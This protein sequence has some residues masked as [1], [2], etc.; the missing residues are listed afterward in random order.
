MTTLLNDLR[1]AWRQL[2]KAPGFTVTA[3]LTLALGIGISAAMFTVVD[4]VLLQPLPVPHSSQIVVLGETNNAGNLSPSSLP[5]L[6][7]W[8]AQSKSFQDI[9]WYTQKFF[10]M[11][12]ADGTTQFSI[13][14][15]TSPNFFS[16]LR[17]QPL[18]GRTFL[19]QAGT[20]GNQGTV[21]LSDFVWQNN[22]HS[23]KNIVGKQIQLGAD[24]YTVVGVLPQQFYIPS[25]D[26][27][28]F[29]WTVLPHI[30]DME[31]RG[32]GFLSGIGR[33]HPGVSVASAQAELS[34]IQG[35]LARQFPDL[36]MTK[37]VKV[38]DY[39]DSL[40]ASARPALL[41]LQAAVLLVWLIACANIAGLMLTRMAARRKEIAVRA[42]LGAAR[43]RIVRQFL[44]ESLVIGV[45]GGACG[46]GIAYA[47]L[48]VLRHSIDAS[49]NRSHEIALNWHVILLLITLSVVSAVIFGT[50]PAFQ[51]SSAD[52]QEA[53]HETS[54]GA[55]A[56]VKQVRLRNA[57]IVGELALSLV[58]LVSAGLMLRTLYALR[59]VPVGFNP[60]HL[61]VAQFFSK[62]GFTP[63]AA[64]PNSADIR[65]A[66]YNPLLQRVRTVPGV[67]SAALVTATPLTNNVHMNASF[68]VIGN[69]AANAAGRSV[70]LHAVTPGAYRTL[71]IR[72]L[73]GRVFDDG[74]RIGTLPV[75][76]VNQS[77]A[78]Q[79]LGSEP[80]QQRL[81]L[82]A[83]SGAKSILQNISVIGVVEDTP[84]VLGQPAVPQVDI[85]LN[86]LPIN[87][88]FYPIVSMA[89][90]LAVRTTQP[91]EVIVP[92]ISRIFSNQNADI[93][94]NS[95]QTMP[96]H[97][98][99]Q[100][101]SQTLAARL[102]WIFAIAAVLIAAAGLYGLL[103]Y[104]VGQRTREIGVRLALGAQRGDVLRMILRQ[105]AR[106]L[107]FGLVIG[108]FAAFFTTRLVRSFLYGVDQHDL[109]TIVAVSILLLAVGLVASYLPAR[110]AARIEPVE[111][112]RSE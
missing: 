18:M 63:T 89:M 77:F 30:A 17:A 37:T 85:D 69:P 19:P 54:R 8:R 92:T 28:P 14:V 112:L 76:I 109:L 46:L 98:D 79:Y 47:C 40:V 86:Q 64:E 53:L 75:M 83:D 105:A 91:P 7:D 42:A 78:R 5:N 111:A 57:L 82:D 31:Q 97:I 29:V 55:G 39:L 87:D 13:N 73:Q 33:L 26:S 2:L 94:V 99:D 32:N 44:T 43:G 50:I 20:A 108:V 16:L 36:H 25:T 107:I 106:L 45:A 71:Q 52:P 103:S 11:K 81:N 1:Y 38:T 51:A 68:N 3:V 102:L 96:Q 80:L 23:D 35:N 58:L 48:A 49:V 59:N 66:F 22:F 70:E 12:K 41:A 84:N 4:G 6:R 61:V 65:T 90:E 56:G 15:Q 62:G 101:G 60:Q 24:T 21:V 104:N 27:G 72:L 88:D 74:D 34:G 95:I 9:A 100:L 110:R 10:D 67:E 93:I